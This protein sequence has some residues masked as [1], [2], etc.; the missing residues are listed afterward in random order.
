MFLV[1]AKH[2]FGGET[3]ITVF[4]VLEF[5]I[6][7]ISVSNY[8]LH[9]RNYRIKQITF[10][11]V[12]VHKHHFSPFMQSEVLALSF[13]VHLIIRQRNAY[14]ATK[15]IILNYIFVQD[16]AHIIGYFPFMKT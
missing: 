4:L 2:F 12:Y 10:N 14:F 15:S 5:F 13:P 6:D 11:G 3:T 1:G 16:T 8:L 7:S 9:I